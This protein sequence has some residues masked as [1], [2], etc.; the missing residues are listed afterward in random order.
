VN[1]RTKKDTV[2]D[3]GD[4]GNGIVMINLQ[5]EIYVIQLIEQLT[6]TKTKHNKI[7]VVWNEDPWSQEYIE[8]YK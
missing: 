7:E 1:R 4:D 8:M 6:Y 5:L 2:I 3:F